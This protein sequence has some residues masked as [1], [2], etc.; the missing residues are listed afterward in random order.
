LTGAVELD[1]DAAKR[2]ACRFTRG[3]LDAI[4]EDTPMTET[5][6]SPDA[7]SPVD[8]TEVIAANPIGR[9]Q[10]RILVL[11]GAAM[12][13]DG[14]DTQAIGYVA[15]VLGKALPATPAELGPVFAMGGVGALIGTLSSGPLA[16]R[17]GRKP[18]IV[19]TLLFFA[20]MSL[21]TS[22]AT[23]PRELMWMRFLTGL[24]LGGVVPNALAL[25]AE[26]MPRK[27]RVTLVM[28]V[29]FGFSLGSGF[30]G[31][32]TA[33]ILQR[34]SWPAV[35][36]AGGLAPLL[37]IAILAWALP[38][39][40]AVLLQRPG[41]G[42]AI[43]AILRKLAPGT[44]LPANP[45]FRSSER[46][47]EGFPVALLFR[48]GRAP[49]TALLWVMFFMNLLA[50]FF[51]N[52]WLPT[53]LNR[54]GLSSYA[55]IIIGSVSHFGGIAGGLLIAPLSDRFNR[56]LV[57]AGAFVLSSASIAG[58]GLAGGAPA[59]AMLA[60]FSAGFFT[61]GAQ[62]AA[63]AIAAT[64]YPTPM[65][66][67]G[68]AWALGIGRSG[69]IIGPY[70]GGLLLSMQWAANDIMYVVAIPGLVAASAAAIINWWVGPVS[71]AREAW[72]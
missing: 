29:W 62:N 25:A 51:M 34:F 27:M 50:L 44:T 21:A 22:F 23:T 46:R 1:Q 20:L 59:F 67:T 65:R 18:V 40:P 12:F 13:M 57:L 7:P 32:I 53:V 30:A 26:Y 36:V 39:S 33:E 54:A 68:T 3:R 41:S 2:H 10:V 31:E 24:G 56:F 48:E 8:V 61:F 47:E 55:A 69:Q 37:L 14:F 60:V 63:N 15:P 66:S 4:V 72:H 16:D 35:F 9:F 6:S 49:L 58:I 45:I 17:L 28:M 43:G 52:S 71:G 38:E 5:S 70:I 11:C 19:G 64:G 42:P